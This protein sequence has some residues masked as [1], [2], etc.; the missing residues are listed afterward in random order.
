M[1]LQCSVRACHEENINNRIAVDNFSKHYGQRGVKFPC[2]YDAMSPDWGA[3]VTILMPGLRVLHAMVWPSCALLLG[4]LICAIFCS[5]C[6]KIPILKKD[7]SK[8]DAKDP[9]EEME[10]NIKE[11]GDISMDFLRKPPSP[12]PEVAAVL[13]ANKQAKEAKLAKQAKLDL[14]AKENREAHEIVVKKPRPPKPPRIKDK[15]KVALAA[16]PTEKRNVWL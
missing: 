9:E 8:K 14:I 16:T 5:R 13:S 7:K 11:D 10:L 3:V 1:S 2:Y 6:R 4:T 12:I 15:K